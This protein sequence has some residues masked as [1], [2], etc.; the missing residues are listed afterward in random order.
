M[1]NTAWGDGHRVLYHW[2]R[3]DETRLAH[4]LATRTIYCSSPA[5]FNDPWDCKPHFNTEVLADPAENERHIAW[6]VDLC[7][8]HNRGMSEADIA[9]MQKTL[10]ENPAEG[11]ALIEQLS[12]TIS[13]DIN[14]RYRV[15]CLAPEVSN[16]LMWAHYGNSHKGICLEFSLR[17]EVL[18]SALRCEYLAEFPKILAH[19]KDDDDNLQILLAKS[20]AWAY[21]KEYRL[22]AQERS[23]AISAGTLTT[24]DSLLQIP[25]GALTAVIV[26]C[27]GDFDKVNAMVRQ[28]A[29]GVKV[30]RAVRVP[31]RYQIRIEE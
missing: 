20:E 15:Y 3:F 9:R 27:Q 13:P 31:N 28:L 22:V 21:E 29:P 4:S 5:A 17:N 23:Q 8:R 7:R 10:R 11:A 25:E 26:G 19:S 6:A 18:C 16:L 14:H 2:Q 1:A 30:K 24:E 12:D